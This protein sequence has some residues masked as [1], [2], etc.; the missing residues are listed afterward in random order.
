MEFIKLIWIVVFFLFSLTLLFL[1]SKLAIINKKIRALDAAIG[2]CEHGG[3]E[4]PA[5]AKK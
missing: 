2:E 3:T 5:A 4:Q 1:W